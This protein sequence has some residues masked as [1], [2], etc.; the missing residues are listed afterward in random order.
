VQ[1]KHVDLDV[2]RVKI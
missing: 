2:V 1:G